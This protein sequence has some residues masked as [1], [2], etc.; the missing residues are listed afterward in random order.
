MMWRPL[1][2][3]ALLALAVA[4]A[5][6]LAG[7]DQVVDRLLGRTLSAAPDTN[8]DTKV[9][10]ADLPGFAFLGADAVSFRLV[11]SAADVVEGGAFTISVIVDSPVEALGSY[12]V[13][14][15][16][17][18]GLA[19]V[20]DIDDGRDPFIGTP[21][22]VNN[23]PAGGI[24]TLSGAQYESLTDPV[25]QVEVARI[26]FQ[27]TRDGVAEVQFRE[28]TARDIAGFQRKVR[29]VIAEAVVIEPVTPPQE[30]H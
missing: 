27:A 20:T 3:T 5:P 13:R 23:D 22:T 15:A 21:D 1:P 19:Q 9:D 7:P 29:S 2:A 16:Y 24:V 28:A 30:G 6:A 11:A 4:A 10:A 17:P 26:R 18:P 8:A 14:I 12:A 25:G